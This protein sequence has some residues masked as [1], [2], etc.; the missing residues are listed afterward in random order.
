MNVCLCLYLCG[1]VV[2]C[3]VVLYCIVF[4]PGLFVCELVSLFVCLL[5]CLVLVCDLFELFGPWFACWLGSIRLC[6]LGRESVFLLALQ[7]HM[8]VALFLFCFAILVQHA[9]WSHWQRL[10]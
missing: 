2:L 9:G 3:C 10:G 1:L 5:A 4:A 8:F 7:Y 6:Y